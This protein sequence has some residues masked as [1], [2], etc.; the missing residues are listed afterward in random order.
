VSKHRVSYRLIATVL[1]LCLAG[2]TGPPA[3]AA[4]HVVTAQDVAKRLVER[5]QTRE[6]RVTLFQEA[7]ST[8]AAEKQARVLGLDPVRLRAAVPHLSDEELI[9]LQARALRAKDVRAGHGVDGLAILGIMLLIAGLV[10]LVAVADD[11]YYD[12]YCYCY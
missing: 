10:V 3:L 5:V 2:I 1:S 8:P 9:D 11:G 7:L 4:S 6:A 12:D